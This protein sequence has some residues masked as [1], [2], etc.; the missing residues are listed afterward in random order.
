MV[1]N[2]FLSMNLTKG[3]ALGVGGGGVGPDYSPASASGFPSTIS[4]LPDYS[5]A[6]AYK[7][8]VCGKCGY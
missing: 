8:L 3:A 5:H 7:L 4:Q 6:L 2:K 1:M